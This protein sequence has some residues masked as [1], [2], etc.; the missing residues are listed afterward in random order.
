MVDAAVA[1]QRLDV[2][3]GAPLPGKRPGIVNP[4]LERMDRTAQRVDRHG[5][6]DVGR[7]RELF[8][9]SQRQR[10][11]RGR[12]LRPVDQRQPLLRAERDRLQ[13]GTLQRLCA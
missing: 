3:G 10:Q 2:G 11:H 6:G 1:H 7:P 9:R 12:G 4:R 5:G 13:S 8:G